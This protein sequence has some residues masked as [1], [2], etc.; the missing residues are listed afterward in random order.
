MVDV[1]GWEVIS[2]VASLRTDRARLTND[3]NVSSDAW[4][5]REYAISRGPVGHGE[6]V[7]I[8]IANPEHGFQSRPEN[9]PIRLR[10]EYGR[11]RAEQVGHVANRRDVRG[12]CIGG[13]DLR[14]TSRVTRAAF[15]T[16]GLREPHQTARLV[17]D[18]IHR[19]ALQLPRR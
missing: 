4:R 10:V 18:R 13:V 1:L 3:L 16:K 11:Q 15:A 8:T 19:S 12:A 5:Q 14:R 17:N 2:E 6:D 7:G 9:P